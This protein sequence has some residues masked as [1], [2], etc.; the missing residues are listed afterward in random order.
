[1]R[2]VFAI[3]LN[4]TRRIQYQ[5]DPVARN[6]PFSNHVFRVLTC[7]EFHSCSVSVQRQLVSGRR[8]V[9]EAIAHLAM[10]GT[11]AVLELTGIS[12]SMTL[13]LPKGLVPQPSR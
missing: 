12:E 13:P 6:P 2:R 8:R 7:G 3:L 4:P 5:A 10:L 9:Q 1:M 11:E